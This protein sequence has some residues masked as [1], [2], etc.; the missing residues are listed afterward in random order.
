MQFP[1]FSGFAG[2]VDIRGDL[3][4][5]RRR[6]GSAEG[7]PTFAKAMGGTRVANAMAVSE[8]QHRFGLCH[9]QGQ[10]AGAFH[11]ARQAYLPGPELNQR[12]SMPFQVLV[13]DFLTMLLSWRRTA[14]RREEP[15]LRGLS[16]A[17]FM[18]QPCK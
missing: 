2:L 13:P 3:Q 17:G 8:L 4:Q 15:L 5:Q 12:I 18:V 10:A 9:V 14:F 16:S 6:C 11:D 7:A 1:T